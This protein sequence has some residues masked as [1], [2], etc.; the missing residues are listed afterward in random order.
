MIKQVNNMK[1]KF[2]KLYEKWTVFSPNN[3][4]LEEF[5]TIEDA[6][7]WVKQTKDFIKKK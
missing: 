6:I 3:R 7:V 4:G 2:N 5:E 1:I